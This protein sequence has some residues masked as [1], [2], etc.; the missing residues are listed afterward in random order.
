V[1]LLVSLQWRVIPTITIGAPELAIPIAALLGYRY[2]RRG[3]VAVALGGAL[4]PL[5][6][7]YNAIYAGGYLDLYIASLLVC[8]LAGSRRPLVESIPNFRLSVLYFCVFLVLPLALGIYGGKFGDF[9][10]KAVLR[11]EALFYLFLFALGL[12]RLRTAAVVATLV[13]FTVFGILLEIIGLPSDASAVFGGP[14]AELPL[15]GLADLR[16]LWIEYGLDSPAEF[17]TGVGYFFAGRT[18]AAMERAHRLNR[19]PWYQTYGPVI[20]LVIIA[21][22]WDL[23]RYAV[24]ALTG[25]RLEPQFR[26]LGSFYALPCA[27]LLGG[28]L[29]RYRGALLVML[30]VPLLWGL[31]GLSRSRFDFSASRMLFTLHEP[32]VALGFGVLGLA[33]RDRA[34]ETSTVWWSTRWALYVLLLLVV[35]PAVIAPQTPLQFLA[36]ALGVLGGIALGL[37]AAWISKRFLG[38]LPTHGGWLS[39]I[40]LLILGTLLWQQRTLITTL[41]NM[42]EVMREIISALS[43]AKGR[44]ELSNQTLIFPTV[45]L[46][47]LWLLLSAAY[48]FLRQAPDCARDLKELARV[49]RIRRRAAPKHGRRDDARPEVRRVRGKGRG[50]TMLV[51]TVGATR[52]LAFAVAITF[53]LLLFLIAMYPREGITAVIR[54]MLPTA[55]PTRSVEPPTV[56][57]DREE[58]S[59]NFLWKA[60][61]EYVLPM[62]VIEADQLSGSIRTDWYTPPG[63]AAVRR[64]IDVSVGRDLKSYALHV[65]LQ[66][67]NRG[68][69][70]IWVE[71]GTFYDPRSRKLVGH[72]VYSEQKEIERQIF[73]RAQALAKAASD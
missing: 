3:L 55:P 23:N 52:H 31:E 71:Q 70:G 15:Y 51:D 61:R 58:A 38:S 13:G 17:L 37:L 24:S 62:S 67:Q 30:L 7:S 48:G 18:L 10:V 33:L 44:L 5:S 43:Q 16:Y 12:S 25:L 73:E 35:L 41:V 21:L 46:V 8:V 11:F 6:W 54:N 66:R 64:R 60:V 19:M 34:L 27:A 42:P 39:L 1:L 68:L 40:S 69:L 14:R 4:L 72:D 56:S 47:F 29:L 53:P 9:E 22:G 32:L 26:I 2:Q 45:A 20:L 49:I 63:E 57:A 36:L 59:N 65:T 50:W 28:L